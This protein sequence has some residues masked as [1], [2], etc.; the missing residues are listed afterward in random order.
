MDSGNFFN[1]AKAAQFAGRLVLTLNDAATALMISIGHRTGLFDAM[2]DLPSSGVGRIAEASGQNEP[3][4]KEWLGATVTAKIADY[5]AQEETY[6]LPKEHAAFLTRPSAP[7]NLAAMAQY[8]PLLGAVEDKII[9]C[10]RNGG[11][12]YADFPRFH[13]IV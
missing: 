8:I 1:E 2:A 9:E 11:L 10:F 4:V 5:D 12:S 7:N 6:R 13:F 3:Y